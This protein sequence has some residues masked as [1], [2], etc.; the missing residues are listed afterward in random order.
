MLQEKLRGELGFQGVIASDAMEMGA[1][2]RQYPVEEACILAIQA[3]VDVLLC[4]REYTKAYDAVLEAV[5]RGDLS[6]ARIDQSVRRI[7]TL[8]KRIAAGKP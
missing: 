5:L 1:I 4:V 7:L 2:L 3:G 6:E 8:K